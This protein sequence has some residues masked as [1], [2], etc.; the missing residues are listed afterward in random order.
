MAG[1]SLSCSDYVRLSR[2]PGHPRLP[3]AGEEGRGCPVG[4]RRRALG[5]TWRRV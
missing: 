4:S 1:R 2:A 5:R 3:G